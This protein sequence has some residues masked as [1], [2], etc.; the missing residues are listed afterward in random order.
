MRKLG[1]ITTAAAGAALVFFGGVAAVRQQTPPGLNVDTLASRLGLSASAKARIAPR[2]KELNAL[3][4]RRDQIRRQNADLR[5]EFLSLH[6]SLAQILTPEQRHGLQVAI[7]QAWAGETGAGPGYMGRGGMGVPMG[8]AYMR[9]YMGGGGMGPSMGNGYMGR[10][11]MGGRGGWM[12]RGR[13][14]GYMGGGF[15]RGHMRGGRVG[16][17]MGNGYMGGYMGRGYMGAVPDTSGVDR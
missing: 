16:P 13:M 12:G 14:G 1:T 3:L 15:M 11:M 4:Q 5:N 17:Y 2:I 9:G 7:G 10:G 8:G 6:D